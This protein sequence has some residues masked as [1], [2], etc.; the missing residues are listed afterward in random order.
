LELPRPR[1]NRIELPLPGF[2]DS[3]IQSMRRAALSDTIEETE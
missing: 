2:L 1:Q 3:I